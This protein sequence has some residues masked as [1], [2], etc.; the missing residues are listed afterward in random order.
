MASVQPFRPHS[1]AAQALAPLNTLSAALDTIQSTLQTYTTYSSLSATTNTIL[2]ADESLSSALELLRQQQDIHARILALQAEVQS[3]EN[4]IKE[5]ISRARSIRTEIT[6]IH[7][8]IDNDDA[9]SDSEPPEVDYQQLLNFAARIGKHNAV[10]K[11]EAEKQGE[12]LKNDASKARKKSEHAAQ[13]ITTENGV[14]PATSSQPQPQDPGEIR[15][16]IDREAAELSARSDAFHS[17]GRLPFPTP[18]LLRMGAL[19]LLQQARESDPGDPEGAVD[20]EAEKLVRE[21]EDI[22]PDEGMARRQR[23]KEDKE[24]DEKRRNAEAAARRAE[25]KAA[26]AAA[27]AQAPAQQQQ[28]QRKEA[29]VPQ[30]PPEEKKAKLNLDFP[31]DYGDDDSDDD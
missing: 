19:G 20:R 27:A 5:T 25:Q 11:L 29:Q 1:V 31:G 30:W 10:A 2:T 15:D 28:Q 8:S 16:K 3:L 24:R 6:S 12:R 17:F 4:Q 22:A 26:A 23:E 18:D 9:D 13:A 7:P 14:P 21:T